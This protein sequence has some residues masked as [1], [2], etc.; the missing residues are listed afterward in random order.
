MKS[1]VV[2]ESVY[3]KA[4][5]VFTSES[6][7]RCVMAPDDEDGLVRA[8]QESGAVHAILGHRKYEGALYAAFPP[9]RVLA[10]FGVGHDGLDKAKATA[11]GLF[12]TNTPGTLDDSVAEVTMFLIGAAARHLVT[13]ATAMT[14]GQW[15]P[16]LG[17][18]L[19]GRTLTI[20]G[21]GRIGST[22]AKIASAGFGMHV[23]GYTRASR[24]AH[25]PAHYA[26]LTPDFARAV[27][28]ADFISLHIAATPENAQFINAERLALMPSRAWLINTARGA[29]VDEVAL[30]DTLQSRRIA[31]AALDVFDREP[32]DPADTAHDL[33]TLPNVILAP[34][35]GS[36]TPDANRRMAEAALRNVALAEDGGFAEM[37]LLNP[38][39]L[40]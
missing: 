5:A 13:H 26:E 32:Y 18:E 17:T 29:V 35:I 2:S 12:C 4:E 22:L 28:D 11:A 20:V 27:G 21:C 9:G 37:N 39:V 14:G 38:E 10:R 6:R 3:R 19:R 24:T 33:R 15:Q 7:F 31:G 23:I 1:I 25:Q 34:H 40:G 30:Y 8:I 16:I 36:H